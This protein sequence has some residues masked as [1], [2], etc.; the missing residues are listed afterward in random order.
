MYIAQSNPGTHLFE[1]M[2]SMDLSDGWIQSD[3]IHYA[4]SWQNGIH[5]R[6]TVQHSAAKRHCQSQKATDNHRRI[7][8]PT[9][10]T[11]HG[12]TDVGHILPPDRRKHLNL[13]IVNISC[14]GRSWKTK[15]NLVSDQGV[16]WHLLYNMNSEEAC[17]SSAVQLCNEL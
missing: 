11:H 2:F 4:P 7:C 12:Q 10:H 16:R 14:P 3:V 6:L 15:F 1:T 13:W 17:Q 5:L 8:H 9:K